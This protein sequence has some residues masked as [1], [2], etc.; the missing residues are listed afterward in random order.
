MP[1]HTM[2]CQA[3]CQ[4]IPHLHSR[5]PPPLPTPPT[6]VFNLSCP[7][8]AQDL[9]GDANAETSDLESDR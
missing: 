2:P 7:S 8:L 6:T 3:M 9:E 5:T 4:D 1:Q